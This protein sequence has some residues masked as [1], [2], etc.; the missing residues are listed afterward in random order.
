MWYVQYNY[1][2]IWFVRCMAKWYAQQNPPF[3]MSIA[4][5]S[6]NNNNLKELAT[7]DVWMSS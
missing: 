6:Y 7:E 3:Q 1:Y 4:L 5:S 2:A